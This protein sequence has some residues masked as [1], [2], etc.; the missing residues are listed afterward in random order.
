MSV[1]L[2][3]CAP[4]S[5]E[6]ARK[7]RLDRLDRDLHAGGDRSRWQALMEAKVDRCAVRLLQGTNRS[8]QLVLDLE[9]DGCLLRVGRGGDRIRSAYE[10]LAVHR[11]ARLSTTAMGRNPALKNRGEPGTNVAHANGRTAHDGNPGLVGKIF[12][13]VLV[14]HEGPSQ[15]GYEGAVRLKDVVQID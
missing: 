3:K 8:L 10:L 13:C 11:H 5:F 6:A 9:L 7:S 12:R 1:L 2:I 4:Q 14:R 15:T